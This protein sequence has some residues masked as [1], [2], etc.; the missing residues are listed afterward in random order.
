MLSTLTGLQSEILFLPSLLLSI[1]KTIDTFA[2]SGNI[3]FIRPLAC[4]SETDS[5]SE[6]A[7]TSFG[8]ILSSS[9]A[10]L[11]SRDFSKNATWNGF[12]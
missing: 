8:G 9:E 7:F 4:D 1:R 10:F 12:E 2:A 5:I 3:P 6:T 11:M